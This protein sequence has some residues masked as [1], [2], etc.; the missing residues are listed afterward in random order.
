MGQGNAL[1]T[2]IAEGAYIF[3]SKNLAGM[4]TELQGMLACADMFVKFYRTDNL[5]SRTE[6]YS[7]PDFV[8]GSLV[9]SR[10]FFRVSGDSGIRLVSEINTVFYE[11]D[12]ITYDS[13]VSGFIDRAIGVSGFEENTI[14][15]CSGFFSTEEDTKI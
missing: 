6:Y 15:C 13:Q 3:R 10:D 8:S 1:R 11:S 9:M 7:S 4:I 5:I 2:S 12:G 14:Q